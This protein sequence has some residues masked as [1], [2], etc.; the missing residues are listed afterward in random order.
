ML[1][2][3]LIGRLGIDASLLAAVDGEDAV[4]VDDEHGRGIGDAPQSAPSDTD[5]G[6]TPDQAGG[7][8]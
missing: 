7:T 6:A 3:F 4:I 2:C 1:V 8:A 5:A